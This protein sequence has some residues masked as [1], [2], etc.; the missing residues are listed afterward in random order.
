V[1]QKSHEMVFS[2]LAAQMFGVQLDWA[3]TDTVADFNIS[4][5]SKP[6]IGVCGDHVQ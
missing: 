2:D 3:F 6:R 5:G 1:P 4:C